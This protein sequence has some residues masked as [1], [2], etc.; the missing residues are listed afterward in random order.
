MIVTP[1]AAAPLNVAN[2]Y[3]G[4]TFAYVVNNAT[5]RARLRA[6]GVSMMTD[7]VGAASCHDDILD[8]IVRHHK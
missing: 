5:Q 2:D 8:P 7:C 4:P 3:D 1:F 6:A